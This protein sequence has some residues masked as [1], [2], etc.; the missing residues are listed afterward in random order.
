MPA[1]APASASSSIGCRRIFPPMRTAWPVS[2][3]RALYE[4]A[5]PREGFHQ[6]W[7]TYIYNFGRR[8][9]QGFLI[10][11]AHPLAGAFPRRWPARRCGGVDAV[12]RLQPQARASGFPTS[13]A[14]ARIWRR[15]A[16]CATS[17][18]W[19]AERC[20]GAITDRRG[21]HRLA[22]RVAAVAKAA[23]AFPSNGT[24]AGCTT[25]CDY[26]EHDPVHRRWHHNDMTF[27]LI[28]AFCREL[29]AAAVA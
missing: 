18:R 6:D 1:I 20:P 26:M 3:A 19:C 15:S 11:S 25:R 22:R 4:H 7:N 29:H 17:T 14:G 2:T 8:E 5:D 13:M 24:W 27:G 9:V 12:S 16:S 23:W 21:I 10:A 28:Y